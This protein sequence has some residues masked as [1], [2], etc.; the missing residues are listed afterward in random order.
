MFRADF[1]ISQEL[2]ANFG[3]VTKIATNDYNKII[4]K[5]SIE[6]ITLQGDK[7]FSQLGL[8]ELTEQEIDKILYGG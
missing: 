5:P 8:D 1:K 3:T 2:A 7:T 6:G 4:N